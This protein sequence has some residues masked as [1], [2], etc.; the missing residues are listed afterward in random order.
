MTA[1]DYR[2]SASPM[3]PTFFVCFQAVP[4]TLN[5]Q[6]FAVSGA[7]AACW[8][9][10][11]SPET[12]YSKARFFVAKGEW[13]VVRLETPPTEVVEAAFEGRE[14]GLVQFRIAQANGIAIAYTCWSKDGVTE[15]GPMPFDEPRLFDLNAYVGS[16]KKLSKSG[17]C[18]HPASGGQCG[19]FIS[20]HSIQRNGQLSVIACEG[21]VYTPSMNVGDLRKN[22]G[23]NSLVKRGISSASTFFGFCDKHDNDLFAPIDRAPL[24]PTSE[25]VLLYAYR[26]ACREILVKEN[27]LD[28]IERQLEALPN[29]SALRQTFER[30]LW[31]TSFS[32]EGIRQ[33]KAT[34]DASISDSAHADVEYV[35]FTSGQP[36][37]V[38]FSGLFYPEFDFL[39]R[40]LQ[41]LMDPECR[42]DLL[43]FCS[44]PI[45]NGWGFL[46][47][48]HKSSAPTCRE[49]MRSLATVTHEGQR[50]GADAMFRMVLSN[51]ENTAFSPVWWE[52]ASSEQKAAVLG[53]LDRGADVFTPTDP[54]Y[55][56]HGAEGV[57]QWEFAGVYV[58]HG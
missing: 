18:L 21:H 2:K 6:H 9:L 4:T 29:A 39:G 15:A 57:S 5:P 50:A 45:Q 28:L 20:A 25:Q 47:A 56:T 1:S 55:L 38:A 31:G 8:V 27:A 40:S 7:Y 30:M 3:G 14:I 12:A 13:E 22:D 37:F 32:L 54:A 44:A 24:V 42:F 48:W 51:C 23:R 46:F 36:Q 33:H 26:S 11:E 53:C 35:L 16:M 52:Q 49:F 43:T 19:Q 58:A 17:R 34:L 10:A 41:D